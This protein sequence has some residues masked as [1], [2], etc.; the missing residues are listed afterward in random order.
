[1]AKSFIFIG[2]SLSLNLFIY[3]F[4]IFVKGQTYMDADGNDDEGLNF[5]PFILLRKKALATPVSLFTTMIE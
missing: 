1:M 3:L 2:S 4:F 5:G